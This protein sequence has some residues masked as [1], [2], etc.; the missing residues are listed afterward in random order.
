[1]KAFYNAF[2]NYNLQSYFKKSVSLYQ[3]CIYKDQKI[4]GQ[5]IIQSPAEYTINLTTHFLM[6]NDQEY[7]LWFEY[8]ICF[9]KEGIIKNLIHTFFN[10]NTLYHGGI[11]KYYDN[12]AN[13][14]IPE[15]IA[16]LENIRPCNDIENLELPCIWFDSPILPFLLNFMKSENYTWGLKQ[17]GRGSNQTMYYVCHFLSGPFIKKINCNLII[18]NPICYISLFGLQALLSQNKIKIT[19]ESTKIINNIMNA[20]PDTKNNIT[21]KKK[22]T[23]L[24]QS[25]KGKNEAYSFMESRMNK[26]VNFFKENAAKESLDIF[27][28]NL[29][30][31]LIQDLEKNEQMVKTDKEKIQDKKIT[32]KDNFFL[33]LSL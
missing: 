26:E 12:C 27:N 21:F 3:T 14:D 18:H 5:I 28:I 10:V 32:K 17:Y 24:L 2:Q 20:Q 19:D 31:S 6:K 25:T 23:K 30:T 8:S 15:Y 13:K 29:K 33:L 22:I 7:R 4:L 1:N 11:S 9:C 16:H